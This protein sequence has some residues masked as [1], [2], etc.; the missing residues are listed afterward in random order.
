MESNEEEAILAEWAALNTAIGEVLFYVSNF[1]ETAQT[2]LLGQDMSPLRD[3]LVDA[4]WQA[5][6]NSRKSW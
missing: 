2:R 5:G 6:F 1:P 3:K 4:V